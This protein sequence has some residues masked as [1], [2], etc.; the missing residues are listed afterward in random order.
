MT[1][2]IFRLCFADDFVGFKPESDSKCG[3]CTIDRRTCRGGEFISLL[4]PKSSR[5]RLGAKMSEHICN[6]R[7]RS[8]TAVSHKYT[9]ASKAAAGT[10]AAGAKGEVGGEEEEEEETD[11][12]FICPPDWE[13]ADPPADIPRGFD[14]FDSD[15]DRGPPIPIGGPSGYVSVR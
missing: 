7:K 3:N 5:S 15:D 8:K 2:D 1:V 6:K 12:D 11:S 4:I 13:G 9:K 10:S 14:P